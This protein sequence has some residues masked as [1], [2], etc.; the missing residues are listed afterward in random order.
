MDRND[1]VDALADE[2][3]ANAGLDDVKDMRGFFEKIP[4]LRRFVVAAA[5]RSLTARKYY[6][7]KEK[8]EMVFEPD[9]GTQMKAV[10]WIAAY[11]DGLPLQST[12][13]F[14]VNKEAKAFDMG[15][16]LANSPALR[17]HL[18]RE[19]ARTEAKALDA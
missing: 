13:N 2:V 8:K 15:D 5:I 3:E 11:Q 4:Q 19:L 17:E 10:A 16:A 6:Y 18:K 12:V 14:N 7:S 1:L 9:S